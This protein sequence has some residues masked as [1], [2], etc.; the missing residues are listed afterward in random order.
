MRW[1]RNADAPQ[2]S[3]PKGDAATRSNIKELPTEPNVFECQSCGKVFEARRLR[4]A[5]P[6]CDSNDVSLMSE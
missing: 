1:R 6:E 4:P 5:C 2:T 3:L